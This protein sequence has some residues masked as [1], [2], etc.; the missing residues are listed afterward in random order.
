MMDKFQDQKKQKKAM[1]VEKIRE[2]QQL[3]QLN[4]QLQTD[5]ENAK[6]MTAGT[7]KKANEA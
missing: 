5:F 6:V 2:I 1:E 3:Q 7:Q 4:N